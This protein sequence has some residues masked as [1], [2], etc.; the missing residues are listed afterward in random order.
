M[1]RSN[2]RRARFSVLFILVTVTAVV[3]AASGPAGAA[4]IGTL[5]D[6]DWTDDSIWFGAAKPTTSDVA[7][8]GADTTVTFADGMTETVTDL[9]VGHSLGSNGNGMRGSGLLIVT[10]GT[11]TMNQNNYTSLG[12]DG[13]GNIGAPVTGEIRQSGGELALR[14][15]VLGEG[16]NVGIYQLSGGLVRITNNRQLIIG[17]SGGATS[18]Q[19]TFTVSG[20]E[21]RVGGTGDLQVGRSGD[22]WLIQT[23]GVCNFNDLVRLGSDDNANADGRIELSGG[24][25]NIVTA[26]RIGD[27]EVNGTMQVT[28]SGT[29]VMNVTGNIDVAPL[30]DG[31][32]TQTGGVVNVGGDLTVAASAVTGDG[33]NG[34]YAMSGGTLSVTGGIGVGVGLGTSTGAFNMSGGFVEAAGMLVDTTGVWVFSG[35]EVAFDSLGVSGELNLVGSTAELAF[36]DA[37]VNLDGAMLSNVGAGTLNIGT[38][39]LLLWNTG[40]D[41]STQFGTFLLSGK[42]HEVGTG[43][44]VMGAGEGFKGAGTIT[45][46]LVMNVGAGTVTA[47]PSLFLTGGLDAFGGIVDLGSGAFNFAASTIGDSGNVTLDTLRLGEGESFSLDSGI[48]NAGDVFIGGTVAA[49]MTQGGGILNVTDTDTFQLGELAGETGSYMLSAGELNQA[50]NV[51]IGNAGT[52]V[53]LQTGGT[54]IIADAKNLYLGDDGGSLGEYTISGGSLEVGNSLRVGQNGHGVFTMTGGTVTLVPDLGNTTANLGYS[55][56]GVGTVNISGGVLNVVDRNINVGRAG[57]GVWLQSGG[58]VVVA[59]NFHLANNNNAN[60]TGFVDLSGGTLD[61][62]NQVFIGGHV[63]ANTADMIVRDTGVLLVGANMKVGEDDDGTLTVSGGEVQ[64]G[65][66]LIIADNKTGLLTQTGGVVTVLDELRLGNQAGGSGTLDLSGGTMNIGGIA[67]VGYD[68]AATNGL[69][70]VSGSGVLNANGAELSV[71]EETDGAVVQT[72]GEVNVAGDLRIGDG[73]LGDD[74]SYAISAGELN[75]TGETRVGNN[76]FS[77]GALT[78]SGSGVVNIAALTV[79]FNGTGAMTLSGTGVV[80]AVEVRVGNNGTGTLTASG[81]SLDLDALLVGYEAGSTG[82]VSISGTA[83]VTPS[84]NVTVGRS[85]AGRLELSGGELTFGGRLNVGSSTGSIGSVAMS[86]GDMTAGVMEFIGPFSTGVFTQTGGTNTMPVL[87]VGSLGKYDY[88]G[89]TL[90]ITHGLSVFTAGIL[91]LSGPVL[92]LDFSSGESIVELSGTILNGGNDSLTQGGGLLIVDSLVGIGDDFGTFSS[93]AITHLGGTGLVL[94]PDEGFGGIGVVSDHVT[95]DGGDITAN[96]GG[97]ID[98]LDGLTQVGGNVDLGGGMLIVNDF[99]SGISGG[100]LTVSELLIGTGGG[101]SGRFDHVSGVVNVTG[102]S[103][104][105]L[106]DARPTSTTWFSRR[107]AP[108]SACTFC[109]AAC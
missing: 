104:L 107:T 97:F 101:R 33:D 20:G 21:L 109:R 42:T 22:G 44:I 27:T 56:S 43:D 45:D 10:G 13:G 32:M 73:A 3:L 72:G 9:R 76:A 14:T 96:S 17:Y 69:I 98:L 64:V 28:V 23:G 79:G 53:F 66:D 36:T 2:T 106:G 102:T 41:P 90:I 39:A 103:T 25:M 19:S 62:G 70:N 5:T 34:V 47:A 86:G 68:D 95:T 89:G 46:K 35:G 63:N 74:G 55:A 75:V 26:L 51:Y 31:T 60:S 65:T 6:G 49:S 1:A 81:G 7:G 40:N 15:T 24:V 83:V 92:S 58:S 30:S 16:D 18:G 100:T 71:A 94:D 52:G 54:H 48:L 105:V 80:N 37:L 4:N 91:N 12:K 67:A 50:G 77:P 93:T 78:V 38:G 108:R 59:S 88:L 82:T 85:G 11:L 8:I 57:A 61:V 99:A 29:G 84:G 87:A